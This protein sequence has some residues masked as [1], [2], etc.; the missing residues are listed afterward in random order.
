MKRRRLEDSNPSALS[1]YSGIMPGANGFVTASSLFPSDF[2][3]LESPRP[4]TSS[5]SHVSASCKPSSSAGSSTCAPDQTSDPTYLNELLVTSRTSMQKTL[6]ASNGREQ[7]S[8]KSIYSKTKSKA[9]KSTTAHFPLP[10][11]EDEAILLDAGTVNQDPHV[12]I[13]LIN[14]SIMSLSVRL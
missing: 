2:T 13:F 7:R 12:W 9:S 5:A 8:K 1:G 14:L 6:N 10:A 11:T 4:A 3:W